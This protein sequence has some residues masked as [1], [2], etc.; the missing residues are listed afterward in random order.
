MELR[1]GSSR[2]CLWYVSSVSRA[3]EVCV[4]PLTPCSH[5]H[6]C[7]SLALVVLIPW[8]HSERLTS[9]PCDHA[10]A[11]QRW[12]SVLSLAWV[13]PWESRRF[14]DPSLEGGG[15]FPNL[16]I[17]VVLESDSELLLPEDALGKAEQI[18]LFLA[19]EAKAGL[20]IMAVIRTHAVPGM[21]AQPWTTPERTEKIKIK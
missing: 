17:S 19:W 6:T 18:S 21:L 5:V 2:L 11:R 14:R 7:L 12:G 9:W 4:H 1:A 13:N 10:E 15:A 20:R 16:R 3:G 8:H